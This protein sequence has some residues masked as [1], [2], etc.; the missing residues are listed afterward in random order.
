ME[1]LLVPVMGEVLVLLRAAAVTVLPV[2]PVTMFLV[3]VVL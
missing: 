3:S 2:K 1:S